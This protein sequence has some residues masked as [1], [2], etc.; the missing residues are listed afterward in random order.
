MSVADCEGFVADDAPPQELLQSHN[1]R[2]SRWEWC[3]EQTT[4]LTEA[5]QNVLDTGFKLVVF[6][7]DAVEYSNVGP[8]AIEAVFR[9]NIPGG[10]THTTHTLNTQFE[11]YFARRASRGPEAKPLLILMITDGCPEDPPKLCSSILR[12]TRRMDHEGEISLTVLQIGHDQTAAK[13]IEKLNEP[14]M[15]AGA[16]FKIVTTRSFAEL[17][18]IGLTGALRDAIATKEGTVVGLPAR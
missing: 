13:L 17:Q 3:R 12:A 9:D 8:S 5:T 2:I 7:G 18:K 11:D 1:A 16:K 10:P 14:V 15:S 4:R 6:S